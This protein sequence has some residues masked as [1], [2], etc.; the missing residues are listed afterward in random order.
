MR[1]LNQP[2]FKRKDGLEI[3]CF[4]LATS[5]WGFFFYFINTR[6][7]DTLLTIHPILIGRKRRE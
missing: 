1:Y 5:G 3:N 7:K 2:D 6:H 4:V